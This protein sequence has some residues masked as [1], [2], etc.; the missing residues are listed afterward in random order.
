MPVKQITR[1]GRVSPAG[2]PLLEQLDREWR[3]PDP[4]ASQPLIIEEVDN[5]DGAAHIYVVWDAWQSLSNIERSEV[6]VEAFEQ[7]YGRDRAMELVI[8]MGLTPVEAE[9]MGIE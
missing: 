4:S 3:N 7:R 6:I 9:R 2:R 1:R 5:P 8:A